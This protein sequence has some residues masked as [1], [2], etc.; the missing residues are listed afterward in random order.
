MQQ[1]EA[2]ALLAA[3]RAGRKAKLGTGR[4]DTVFQG[5]NRVLQRTQELLE[6]RRL[7]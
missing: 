4:V 1:I 2:T 6:H 3:V 5:G 7:W